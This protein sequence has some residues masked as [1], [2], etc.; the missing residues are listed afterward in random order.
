[1]F[2]SVFA[3]F[4]HRLSLPNIRHSTRCK[5]HNRNA[6]TKLLLVTSLW[7]YSRSSPKRSSRLVL[8]PGWTVERRCFKC[9]QDGDSATLLLW[10]PLQKRSFQQQADFVYSLLS[11]SANHPGNISGDSRTANQFCM[12]V[13]SD[14][15]PGMNLTFMHGQGLLLLTGAKML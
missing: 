7:V 6:G 2:D 9:K 11:S 14:I 13:L 3:W 10:V 1:M 8:P 4:V 12:L 15:L 5:G